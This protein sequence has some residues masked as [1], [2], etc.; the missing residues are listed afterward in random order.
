MWMKKAVKSHLIAIGRFDVRR[1]NLIYCDC[2]FLLFLDCCDL[3]SL[4]VDLE[5]TYR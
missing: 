4:V 5:T 1:I 2:T 3:L